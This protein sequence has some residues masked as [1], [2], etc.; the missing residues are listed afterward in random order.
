MIR[1]GTDVGFPMPAAFAF[2]AVGLG[3]G[4]FERRFICSR[5]FELGDIQQFAKGFLVSFG[6]QQA[7]IGPAE[8]QAHRGS[9]EVLDSEGADDRHGESRAD[10]GRSEG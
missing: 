3:D 4:N 2:L 6:F 1:V 8:A 9:V 7:G 10:G 5:D